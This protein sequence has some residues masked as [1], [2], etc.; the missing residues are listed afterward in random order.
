MNDYALWEVILNGDS[1]PP[2]R[3][4]DGVEKPYPPTTVDEKLGRKNKLKARDTEVSTCSKAYLKSYETLKEHY[5]NL[6]KDFNKSQ[7][8]LGA[9]KAG[10][11]F[12][13]ARLKVYKK[14]EVV[15]E[16]DTN[17]L[18]LDVIFRDKAIKE[19]RQKFE[20]AEKRN[21]LKLTLEK[22]EV[23][24]SESKLKTVGAPINEAWVSDSEDENKIETKTKQIK[25]SFA[26]EKGVIDSGCSRYMTR[27]MSYIFE[28]EEIDGGYVAFGGDLKGGKIT[29][30]DTECV[31]LS[32]NFKLLNESQVLLRVPKKNNMYSVDL[33]NVS[34][35]GGRKPALSFMRPFRC[36][37]TILNT[38]DHLGKFDGKADEGFFIG[39]STH[40]KAFRVFNNRTKIVK[41]NLH[42]TF[43]EKKPNVTGIG[44]NWMLDIDSLTMSMNYQPDFAKNQTN[45]NAE[46]EVTNDAG[47]KRIEVPRKENRVHDPA[48]EGNKTDQEKDVRD[49]E[50]PPRQQFEQESER[51]FGQGEA[52]NT[53]STNRLNNVSLPV[54]TVSSSFTTVDLGR[55]RAQ[56]NEFESMFGQ[57]KDANGNM[58]FTPI[59]AAGSTYVYLGGSI[60]INA[61]TLPNVDLPTDP[62]MLDL[63]DTADTRIFCDAYDDEVEGAKVDFNSLE[64]TTV[65]RTNYKDDQNCLLACFL[66]Q[67][68]PKKVI[69]ALTNPSWIEA[70][71]K[72]IRLFLAYASFMG[73]IVYQMDVKSAFLYVT[74]EE[75]VYVC[76][77]LGL[78]DPHFPNKVYKVE[79]AL[80]GLHQAP[81]AWINAQEVPDEFYGEAHFFL[82]LQV[83]QKDDGIFISQDNYVADILKKFDFSLVKTASTPI[84]TNKALLKDEEAVDVDVHLYR[85]MIGSLMYLTA[86]RPDIMFTICACARFKVT[87]KV[88]HLHAMK[89]IFRYLKGQPNLGLWYP[90]D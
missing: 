2:T 51:L 62:F 31:V 12:V 52:A 74:I 90:R 80:Y 76:Q 50:E 28:Y 27:N 19:L 63:E 56:R 59:G 75:E 26:K 7:F 61:A 43:L 15:F 40:S 30:K 32:P 65:R 3:S 60:P 47:K 44:P 23:E 1:P 57:D 53:N 9:Y 21:D 82:G 72:A 10:L 88:S 78:E 16:D 64:L 5:D 79:K 17:I 69:Q 35:S 49:Q 67:M 77:P 54:N 34:P 14:N 83:M 42:I 4:V 24:T 18:K 13:E 22:F 11:K 86:S 84:E 58:I 87:P 8:N 36:P 29:C 68:E 46:D 70:M 37:V 81:K 48:K 41:E 39:Y 20:K 71:I 25:P 6:I 85:S 38:L 45:G 66:S 73:F 55:E 89:R 33:R